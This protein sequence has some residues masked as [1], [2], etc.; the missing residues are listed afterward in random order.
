MDADYSQ[1][2]LRVLAS[3]SGDEQLIDAYRQGGDHGGEGIPYPPGGGDAPAE[4]ECEGSEFR[5]RVWNQ[6]LWAESGS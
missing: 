3:M 6:F 1:I 5:H 2:E 4:K